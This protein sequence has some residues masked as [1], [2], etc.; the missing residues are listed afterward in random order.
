MRRRAER[1]DR[2]EDDL[3]RLA[4]VVEGAGEDKQLFLGNVSPAPALGLEVGDQTASF[5][6]GAP[7]SRRTRPPHTPP[8]LP[9]APRARCRRPASRAD[10]RPGPPGR[11][12]PA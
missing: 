10:R 1:G 4:F 3:N 6:T 11:V 7:A 12:S 9:P 8:A 5:V 2:R